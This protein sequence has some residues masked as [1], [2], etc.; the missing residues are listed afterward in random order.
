MKYRNSN[1]QYGYF[2]NFD[3]LC[4]CGHSLGAHIAGGHECAADVLSHPET[5]G[6]DCKKFRP[7]KE[8]NH[9]K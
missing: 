1:G 5:K 7:I 3:R 4:K 9:G 6:C 2:E 8:P